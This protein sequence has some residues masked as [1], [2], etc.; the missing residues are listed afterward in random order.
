MNKSLQPFLIVLIA[1]ATAI[2]VVYLRPMFGPKE[3]IPWRNDISLA[4]A[5]SQN[6]NK[7]LFLY[8]TAKWCGPCQELKTTTWADPK[9]KDA[10]SR[11][12]AV[13]IDID[14][15]PD[16]ARKYVKDAIPTFAV[17]S[18]DGNVIRHNEGA[19]DPEGFLAWLNSPTASAES[20]STQR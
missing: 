11:Y 19:L 12:I 9:V 6:S 10:L 16:F 13:K 18:S 17:V 1:A 2:L 4:K 15:Q 3:I 14:E 7:P 20:P 5:E 8:F